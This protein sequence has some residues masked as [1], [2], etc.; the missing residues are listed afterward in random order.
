MTAVSRLG[1]DFAG[2]TGGMSAN[3]RPWDDSWDEDQAWVETWMPKCPDRNPQRLCEI[4]GFRLKGPEYLQLRVV[5][6]PAD[7]GVCNAII[8]EHPD[9]VYVRA[10]A[11]YD[12][13][14]PPRQRPGCLYGDTDCPCSVWLDAPL[15]ER[16][17]IDVDSGEPRCSSRA[18]Y[19]RAI[20]LCPASSGEFVAT[21]RETG[22]R[23]IDTPTIRRALR[24]STLWD[25]GPM[26]SEA[27][28]NILYRVET[29]G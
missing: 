5:L 25:C 17:V 16:I 20:P 22:R 11:C 18:G 21:G 26:P 24:T 8:E 15:G 12:D 28:R 1:P 6:T 29:E 13:G 7:W 3:R 9:L 2:H 14:W 19:R 4:L 27:K 23:R 10:I